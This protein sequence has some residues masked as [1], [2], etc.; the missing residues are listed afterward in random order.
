MDDLRLKA[1]VNHLG[2]LDWNRVAQEV[3]GF[4]G[5]QCRER[6]N[7]YVNPSLIQGSWTPEEDQLL[8]NSLQQFGSKWDVLD[9]CLP[10]RSRNSIKNRHFQLSRT[11]TRTMKQQSSEVDLST[12]EINWPNQRSRKHQAIDMYQGTFDFM[13]RCHNESEIIWS[14]NDELDDIFFSI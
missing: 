1:V 9:K 13:D 2:T 10:T 14:T 5:R 4:T 11:R 7:N 8:L 6:W 3:G 12:D